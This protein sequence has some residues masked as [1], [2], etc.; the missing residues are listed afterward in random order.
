[1]FLELTID[2]DDRSYLVFL[3]TVHYASSIPSFFSVG[4]DG[5]LSDRAG[6]REGSTA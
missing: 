2:S 1:M 4:C 6:D 5:S 3:P